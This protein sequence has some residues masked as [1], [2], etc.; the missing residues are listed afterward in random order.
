MVQSS[1]RL[2]WH[3]YLLTLWV[4]PFPHHAQPGHWIFV[5]LIGKNHKLPKT[6]EHGDANDGG[7]VDNFRL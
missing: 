7:K 6:I 2:E 5:T 3:P 4:R 1:I